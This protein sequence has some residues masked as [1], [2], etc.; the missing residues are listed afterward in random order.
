MLL[1]QA[2]VEND[3]VT[4]EFTNGPF[5]PLPSPKIGTQMVKE[6]IDE[7]INRIEKGLKGVFA[8]LKVEIQ[9]EQENNLIKGYYDNILNDLKEQSV[10]LSDEKSAIEHYESLMNNI[11]NNRLQD[12]NVV[13]ENSKNALKEIIGN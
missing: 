8:Q 6:W 9:N 3:S 11:I 5:D 7:K 12:A 10:L 13:K 1:L 2:I 4:I